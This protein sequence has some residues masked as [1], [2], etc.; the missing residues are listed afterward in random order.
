VRSASANIE[1]TVQHELQYNIPGYENGSYN[2]RLGGYG[3]D[4]SGSEYAPMTG[5][6]D[7]VYTVM[8]LWILLKAGNF[9]RVRATVNFSRR[10]VTFYAIFS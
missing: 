5:G 9:F 7:S 3:L 8:N 2:N 4:L 10:A 6:V 1:Y